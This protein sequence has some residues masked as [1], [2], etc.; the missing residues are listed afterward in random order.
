MHYRNENAWPSD[1]NATWSM[2]RGP[3]IAASR[4]RFWP[5]RDGDVG[6]GVFPAGEPTHRMPMPSRLI[7]LPEPAR[8]TLHPLSRTQSLLRVPAAR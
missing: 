3:T 6:I 7:V 8:P 4:T 1:L 5:V 2:P